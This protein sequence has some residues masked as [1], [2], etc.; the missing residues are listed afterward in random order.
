MIYKSHHKFAI[1]AP[2]KVRRVAREL[3][4][5]TYNE[6]VAYLNHLPHRGA[7]IIL[8]IAKSAAANALSRD[9][10][11]DEESLFVKSIIVNE[12]PR[13]KRIWQRARGRADMLLKRMS[14]ISVE[15]FDGK[16]E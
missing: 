12:G 6:V 14:H 11:L 7:K 10:T 9:S 8:K 13:M 2:T 15:I 4:G 1:I 5:K 16:K 3:Q